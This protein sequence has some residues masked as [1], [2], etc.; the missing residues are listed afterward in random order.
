MRVSLKKILEKSLING[1]VFGSR[2]AF[3]RE[4]TYNIEKENTRMEFAYSEGM[5]PLFDDEE[6]Y[7]CVI[8]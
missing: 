5:L 1:N 3:L 6:E 7:S 2:I 8:T 4:K